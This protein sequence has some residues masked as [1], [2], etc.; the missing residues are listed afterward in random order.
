MNTQPKII[1]A[2]LTAG[3]ALL[4]VTLAVALSTGDDGGMGHMNQPNGYVGMMQ[5]MGNMDSDGMLEQM[6][7]V[8]GPEGY[9]R[10]LD[11][12]AEHRK[13]GQ[14]AGNA[15]MDSMMHQMMDGMMQ[16]LPADE[17]NIMPMMPG[18]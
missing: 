7:E 13:G 14:T 11:H 18:R 5:A 8:S 15:S 12:I 16:Q 6:R 17:N 1:I 3:V 9:Q 4:A 2:G 10:M